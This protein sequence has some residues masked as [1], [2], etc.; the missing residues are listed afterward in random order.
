MFSH[1][2]FP[3]PKYKKR[4]KFRGFFFIIFRGEKSVPTGGKR[5]VGI[6]R[7]LRERFLDLT[8]SRPSLTLTLPK[9]APLDRCDAFVLTLGLKAA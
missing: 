1:L 7:K 6:C 8:L 4:T 3:G 5:R 2:N 9:L